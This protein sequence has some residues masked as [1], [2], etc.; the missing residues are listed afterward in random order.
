MLIRRNQI[1]RYTR[2]AERDKR[3]SRKVRE[4]QRDIFKISCKVCSRVK[5]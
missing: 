2:K 3:T 4:L 1:G 5:G